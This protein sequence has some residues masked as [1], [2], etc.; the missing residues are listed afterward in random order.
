[1]SAQARILFVDDEQRVLAAMRA[2]F[3]R[4]Y[5]VHIANSG[6]E[7][8]EILREHAI[9]VVV[10]DQR[11]PEMTGVEV[12]KEARQIAPSAMRILLTGYADLAAIED[13]INDSEVFRYLMKPCPAS[14]CA[15][16]CRWRWKPSVQ[17]RRLLPWPT[18]PGA[19]HRKR[20]GRPP[21]RM[22]P[23]S[24]PRRPTSRWS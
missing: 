5:E 18:G 17:G 6:A 11:M 15:R 3:R 10:S 8:L 23:G 14:S 24:L 22:Q 12:L 20:P 1:M 16:P 7:A 19:R 13:A 2:M 21:P 9:D 4:D